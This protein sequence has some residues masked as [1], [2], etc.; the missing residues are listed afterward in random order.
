MRNPPTFQ[1]F[2]DEKHGCRTDIFGKETFVSAKFA[3][4]YD[5]VE[6]SQGLPGSSVHVGR[7]EVDKPIIGPLAPLPFLSD[8]K[9]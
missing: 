6:G 3:F 4:A 2:G 7:Y 5:V 1:P 8:N 9:K